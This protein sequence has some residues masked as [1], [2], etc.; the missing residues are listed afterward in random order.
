MRGRMKLRMPWGN[1]EQAGSAV[2]GK[3]AGDASRTSKSSG[4]ASSAVI[5]R[6]IRSL[7][8]GQTIRG[9]I[10]SRNGSDVQVRLSDDL[11]LQAKIDQNMNLEVG[12]SMTFEVRN[13]GSALTLSPLFE[14]MSADVNVLK[15]LDMAGLPVND[16]SVSMTRQ[17]MEAGLPVDRS[18]L[19]QIY[20]EVAS[21]PQAEVSDVVNLHR[22][23]LPVNE[24]NVNQMISYRNLTHQILDGM[25]S[26]LETLPETLENL[27]Q[28][29]DLSGLAEM[30]RELFA[31]A[32]EGAEEGM[33]PLPEGA[34]PE[35]GGA[36]TAFAASAADGQ[37]DMAAGTVPGAQ[38][39]PDAVSGEQ[40]PAGLGS[41]PAAAAGILLEESKGWGVEAQAAGASGGAEIPAE[42][43]FPAGGE[44]T[45]G[46][47]VMTAQETGEAYVSAV[48]RQTISE[49]LFQ[50]LSGLALDGEEV[51]QLA[52]EIRQFGQGN[53][54]PRS[55]METAGKLLQAARTVEG[56]IQNL[57]RVFSG[58][59]FR[60][61]LLDTL[62]RNWTVSPE[63]LTESGKVEELYRRMDRQLKSLS[64]A[65]E[66]GGGTESAA[67]RAV[68]SMTQNID[69]LNQLNQLYTYVQLPLH[70]RQGDT[71]GE[72]YVYAN[73]KN[74]A[75]NDGKISALL[76][77]D[78]E[79][80]GPVDVYVMM[81]QAKVS[82]R[83][84]V[85]DDEMLDFLAAHMHIL[86]QRLAERGYDCSFSLTTR[87]EE[88]EKGKNSGIRPIL[89]QEKGVLVTQ[90]AFDVRT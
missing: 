54:D 5:N 9:E 16:A 59:A 35:D 28:G 81:E 27:A 13:N 12:K 89:D 31:L 40:A 18:S 48:A 11:V 58:D 37:P 80:L 69:F 8:P 24:T 88:Q 1:V 3:K 53:A 57:H 19:Q 47:A 22:L 4:W 83:F 90:Y 63:E 44:G 41:T 25:E 38:A 30:Y 34:L 17:L 84:Y 26:I 68:T 79:H 73:K 50:V 43:I 52:E 20:R 33:Q 55:F 85:Q 21:F 51:Q 82:T 65:L 67:F 86:T 64:H 39:Q 29:G 46:P 36:G 42:E 23:G 2:G 74:L 60:N 45:G 72:L 70:L 76:H 62:K 61:L 87:E 14:N 6:Q 49:Q 71:Q 66:A 7:V 77:L 78:M 10:L 15:A 56:G 32:R 75:E